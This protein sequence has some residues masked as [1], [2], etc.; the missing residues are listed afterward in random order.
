MGV[1]VAEHGATIP[2]PE[3][4]NFPKECYPREIVKGHIFLIS[5]FV[6]HPV[7]RK[8][9]HSVHVYEV[10]L[11]WRIVFEELF[12]PRLAEI[13]GDM[14]NGVNCLERPY[15]L[16][17]KVCTN[18]CFLSRERVTLQGKRVGK[19]AHPQVRKPLGGGVVAVVIVGANCSRLQGLMPPFNAC[20]ESSFIDD[21]W[22]CIKV[23][24]YT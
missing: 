9:C 22:L 1:Q 24:G 6:R 21:Q 13:V 14:L 2:L 8:S 15:F 19:M 20:R 5:G 23:F 4:H 11:L 17:E 3:Q 16:V 12:E 18:W 10:V 7:E